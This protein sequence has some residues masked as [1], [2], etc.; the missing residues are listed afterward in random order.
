V[1]YEAH[2]LDAEEETA[3]MA[4]KQFERA[5]EPKFGVC[6]GLIGRGSRVQPPNA[7][8]TRAHEDTSFSKERVK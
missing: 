5:Q 2:L 8:T 1:L 6:V 4:R 7:H 3:L